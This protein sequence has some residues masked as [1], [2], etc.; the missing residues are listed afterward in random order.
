MKKMLVFMLLIALCACACACLAEGEQ[1]PV[2]TWKA[3]RVISGGNDLYLSGETALK[4]GMMIRFDGDGSFETFVYTND[5]AGSTVRGV[6][7]L[8]GGYLMKLNANNKV[9]L[10]SYRL[11]GDVLTL[12]ELS[13]TDITVIYLERVRPAHR[14]LAFGLQARQWNGNRHRRQRYDRFGLYLSGGWQLYGPDPFQWTQ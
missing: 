11:S 8:T 14:I 2:G 3:T 1:P 7:E 5:A 13:G 12:T 9:S 10:E 4:A 6:Y